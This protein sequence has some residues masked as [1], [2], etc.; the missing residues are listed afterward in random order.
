MAKQQTVAASMNARLIRRTADQAAD[1]I[2]HGGQQRVDDRRTREVGLVVRTAAAVPE[3]VD[4]LVAGVDIAALV[5][6]A[7]ADVDQPGRQQ[8]LATR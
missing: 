8:R 2:R 4:E 5:A 3:F 7:D 1:V 6:E